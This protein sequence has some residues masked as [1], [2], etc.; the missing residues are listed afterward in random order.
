MEQFP[1]PAEHLGK[2]IIDAAH[3]IKLRLNDVFDREGLN[4]MQART[5]GFVEMN[6]RLV[7]DVYQKDLE[8]EFK[9]SRSSVT[10]LLNTMEKNGFIIR[11]P[12]KNDARLKKIVL[13]E[14]TLKVSA[15]HWAKV[16]DFEQNLVS[17]MTREEIETLKMLL[18]KVISNLDNKE[19]KEK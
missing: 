13:T 11:Q 8:S 1:F 2:Y 14:K 5:I 18:D 9:I 12:V 15:L 3:K 6:T 19:V 4:G 10:S 17:N 16:S 7:K